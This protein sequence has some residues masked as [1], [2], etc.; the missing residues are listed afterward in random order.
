MEF[1]F[2]QGKLSLRD[3]S[4]SSS[5]MVYPENCLRAQFRLL[6]SPT[7]HL[8]VLSRWLLD[9][10]LSDGA[11]SRLA[12]ARRPAPPS[13]FSPWQRRRAEVLG[14]A[15]S[16]CVF[17]WTKW[18]RSPRLTKVSGPSLVTCVLRFPTCQDFVFVGFCLFL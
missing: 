10:V 13:Y 15:S 11:R 7:M 18:R 2:L 1:T 4:S 17:E 8:S 5:W 6:P 3:Y 12:R 16:V 14:S 9:H